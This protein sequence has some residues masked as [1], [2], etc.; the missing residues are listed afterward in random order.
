MWLSCRAAKEVSRHSTICSYVLE[1]TAPQKP[2]GRP[3]L[4]SAKTSG[5]PERRSQLGKSERL[6]GDNARS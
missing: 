6:V 1:P 3:S 4:R 2:S 5:A